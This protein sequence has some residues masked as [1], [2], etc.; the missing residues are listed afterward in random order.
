LPFAGIKGLDWDQ[1]THG[2]FHCWE[3]GLP[4][5]AISEAEVLLSSTG[6]ALEAFSNLAIQLARAEEK[7]HM[8]LQHDPEEEPYHA[9][10]DLRKANTL[11]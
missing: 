3:N 2:L 5:T 8:G 4:E 10:E 11:L 1:L 9:V 6:E 7:K